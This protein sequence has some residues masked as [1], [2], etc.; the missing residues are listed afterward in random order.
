MDCSLNL[1]CGESPCSITME[2]ESVCGNEEIKILKRK[3][4]IEG[5]MF[6]MDQY[7]EDKNYEFNKKGLKYLTVFKLVVNEITGKKSK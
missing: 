5:L 3:K 4:K 2:F 6:L 7:S 1:V